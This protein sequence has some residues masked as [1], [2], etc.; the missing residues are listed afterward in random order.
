MVV[1]QI[2]E[3]LLLDI[4]GYGLGD[5]VVLN[6]SL[7]GGLAR[8]GAELEDT[9]NFR[10]SDEIRAVE[11]SQIVRVD[12]GGLVLAELSLK[13][14][15]REHSDVLVDDISDKLIVLHVTSDLLGE[16]LGAV[17]GDSTHCTE[18]S[19]AGSLVIFE[20]FIDVDVSQIF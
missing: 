3:D 5:L 11:E 10:F 6:K 1:W 12:V 8:D 4:V 18:I 16:C 2:F 14:V 19:A 13:F 20:F 15:S 9:T 7:I 17:G